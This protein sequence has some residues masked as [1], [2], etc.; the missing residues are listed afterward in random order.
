MHHRT[1]AA[2][3]RPGNSLCSRGGGRGGGFRT[4]RPLKIQ[5]P[6]TPRKPRSGVDLGFREAIEIIFDVVGN[7]PSSVAKLSDKAVLVTTPLEL[8]GE[9][10][11]SIYEPLASN[12]MVSEC[13][14]RL[15]NLDRSHFLLVPRTLQLMIDTEAF[16]TIHRCLTFVYGRDFDQALNPLLSNVHQGTMPILG[17]TRDSTT[18]ES[19]LTIVHLNTIGARINGL[20]AMLG[21]PAFT[22]FLMLSGK[23][24][25]FSR[26][27]R[28]D[29]KTLSALS[30]LLRGGRPKMDHLPTEDKR[31][32]E[33]GVFAAQYVLPKVLNHFLA[34]LSLAHDNLSPGQ[35]IGNTVYV[36]SQPPAT[37][38]SVALLPS[39]AVGPPVPQP[40]P[41]YLR[42]DSDGNRL[43]PITFSFMTGYGGLRQP[44][45]L[46][47]P[48]LLTKGYH[49]FKKQDPNL[50]AKL[51]SK[52][53]NDIFTSKRIPEADPAHNPRDD[54]CTVNL[55]PD[56]SD[57]TLFGESYRLRFSIPEDEAD[58]AALM[59]ACED[60][61][62]LISGLP[63]VAT[64]DSANS[65]D[66]DNNDDDDDDD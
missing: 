15:H 40:Q 46:P 3:P 53:L 24:A 41:C 31:F 44:H 63:P 66:E 30:L 16:S 10:Q 1:R 35:L 8:S 29:G 58:M 39:N 62:S 57:A 7:A 22:V 65:D 13:A 5:P 49:R 33:A 56:P 34:A 45:L 20:A 19:P 23:T 54:D 14:T 25:T 11:R 6:K 17:D 64:L 42:E 51:A 36:N 2:T 43:P 59:Q 18:P 26:L 21:S 52:T 48:W 12:S 37:S 55:R 50:A 47:A 38:T 27:L 28:I 60:G 61:L 32:A 9:L 4:D